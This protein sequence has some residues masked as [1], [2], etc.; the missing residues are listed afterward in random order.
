ML[1]VFPVQDWVLPA[2]ESAAS[3]LRVARR[4]SE[5]QGVSGGSGDSIGHVE[6]WR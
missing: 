3:D 1:F 5:V 2:G 4:S 6:F